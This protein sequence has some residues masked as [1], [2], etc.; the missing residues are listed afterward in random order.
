MI[1]TAV[2]NRYAN[3]LVD[4]VMSP[5]SDVKPQDAV[6]QLRS[7]NATVQSSPDLQAV[8]ASPAIPAARKRAV[9]KDIAKLLGTSNVIRNFILVVTDRRRA[10]A[11]AQMADA[12]ELT[13]EQRM[14]FVRAEVK[15]AYELT[16]VQREELAKHLGA[17]AGSRVRLRFEVDPELIGGVTA[18]IGS[19]VYDGS[20]R[21]QLAV[22]RHRLVAGH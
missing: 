20:V 17:L 14:G 7:F 9:I 12:F 11:L 22:M 4:V 8:M 18:K 15:S 5:E 13:L 6:E 21:G 10:G 3:A 16:P 1:S 2:V 19:T